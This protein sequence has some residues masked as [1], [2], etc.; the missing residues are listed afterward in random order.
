MQKSK[1]AVAEALHSSGVREQKQN[2]EA[3]IKLMRQTPEL[4]PKHAADTIEAQTKAELAAKTVQTAYRAVKTHAKAKTPQAAANAGAATP[5]PV[6]ALRKAA[7]EDVE[8]PNRALMDSLIN[9]AYGLVGALASR[10]SAKQKVVEKVAKALSPLK[11][12]PPELVKQ[13][14]ERVNS[15]GLPS[16]PSSRAQAIQT[17]IQEHEAEFRAAPSYNALQSAVSRAFGKGILNKQEYNQVLNQF[18]KKTA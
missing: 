10:A 3:G 18:K 16:S 6:R 17:R 7:M 12:P 13:V 1:A 15:A 14:E 11:A 2:I 8:Q 4:V 9:Q 5:T